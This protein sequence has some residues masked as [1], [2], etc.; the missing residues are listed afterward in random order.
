ME[1][2][3]NQENHVGYLTVT[4]HCPLRNS[5]CLCPSLI[6]SGGLEKSLEEG[7]TVITFN[8]WHPNA[9]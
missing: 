2:L 9:R 8:H 4:D 5:N 6:M 3:E 1:D 7:L